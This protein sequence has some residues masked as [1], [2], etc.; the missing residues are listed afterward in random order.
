MSNLLKFVIIAVKCVKRHYASALFNSKCLPVLFFGGLKI[1]IVQIVFLN[2]Q[3]LAASIRSSPSMCTSLFSWSHIALGVNCV[4]F[5][6]GGN[7]QSHK[8]NLT[9][10]QSPLETHMSGG[11]K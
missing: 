11:S 7:R 1:L 6:L 9:Q 3:F 4:I 2:S 8:C 10:P 5:Q